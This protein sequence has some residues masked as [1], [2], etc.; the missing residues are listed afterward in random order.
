VDKM[1]NV[2]PCTSQFFYKYADLSGLKLHIYVR[3]NLYKVPV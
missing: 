1:G 2:G 3:V